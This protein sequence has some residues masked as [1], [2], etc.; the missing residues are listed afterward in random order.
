MVST[1]AKK[2]HA[3]FKKLNMT[4]YR[5]AALPPDELTFEERLTLW[6]QLERLRLTLADAVRRG[7]RAGS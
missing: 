7:R 6:A 1:E 5:I 3:A 2:A 4:L